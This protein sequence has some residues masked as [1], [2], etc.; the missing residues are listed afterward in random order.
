MSVFERRMTSLDAA[1]PAQRSPTPSYG[2]SSHYA[3]EKGEE[4]FSW[5]SAGGAFGALINAHKFRHLVE[6]SQ[7]VVDFGDAA[8]H[9]SNNANVQKNPLVGNFV[10]DPN[11]VSIGMKA[12]S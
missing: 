9:R 2:P 8:M 6:P 1:P 7:G 10:M 12:S 5:Q 3:G 4:Y 11:I